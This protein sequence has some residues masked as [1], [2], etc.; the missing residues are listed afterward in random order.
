[1]KLG[2]HGRKRFI[3]TS[4]LLG[5]TLLVVGGIIVFQRSSTPDKTNVITTTSPDK[6]SPGSAAVKSDT[7]AIVGSGT[8]AVAKSDTTPVIDPSTLNSV[9]VAPLGVAVSY[10]KG[11]HG[12]NF[13]VK[14]TESKTQYAEFNAPE[15]IGTICTDDNGTFAS[16]IKNPT[17][18]EDQTTITTT[19]KLGDDS[20]GLSLSGKNCTTNQQLLSQYQ[21]AFTNGFSSLKAL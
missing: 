10:T 3:I 21:A 9:D 16:I 7:P 19:T 20:Y 6:A 4:S 12:F 5:L 1:M 11:V 13:E 8:V 15:L 17:S 18:T 14:K 2:A